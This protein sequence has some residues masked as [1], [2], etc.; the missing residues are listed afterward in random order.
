M[1]IIALTG[2]AVLGIV[3][4]ERLLSV[5]AIHS[6]FWSCSR[7]TNTNHQTRFEKL[8][9]YYVFKR[10]VYRRH[11]PTDVVSLEFSHDMDNMMVE[12]PPGSGWCSPHVCH[13]TQ[14]MC[15]ELEILSGV[16]SAF[17]TTGG[18][19][20]GGSIPERV[21]RFGNFG[22][23]YHV[24]RES[25]TA[26]LFGSSVALQVDHVVASAVQDAELY[27]SLCSTPPWLRLLYSFTSK[28]SIRAADV[29]ARRVL[30]VQLRAIFFCSDTWEYRGRC[31]LF[32]LWYIWPPYP[33]WVWDSEYWSEQFFS[34]QFLR[35]NY[36]LARVALG[37]RPWYDE[38]ELLSA[39]CS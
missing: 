2:A 37:M 16:W 20:G 30:W 1:T 35:A 12:I 14:A 5:H 3:V 7:R 27:F 4:V 6:L 34:T 36:W 8:Q 32:R 19:G 13:R 11:I 9:R 28:M 39:K 29:L 23:A 38:Y 17:G 31:E 15:K 26:R 33:D 25:T 21:K 22:I 18:S 24:S 10:N